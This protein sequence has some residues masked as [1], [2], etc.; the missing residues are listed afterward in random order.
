MCSTILTF[1]MTSAS[2]S[3]ALFK[4]ILPCHY[5]DFFLY[6]TLYNFNNIAKYEFPADGKK[7]YY[8]Y[9]SISL[10]HII[11][12]TFFLW[13]N[14]FCFF[15]LVHQNVRTYLYLASFERSSYTSDIEKLKLRVSSGTD[16]E[17]NQKRKY[18]LTVKKIM[19]KKAFSF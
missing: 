3:S 1:A 4:P 16:N 9:F 12:F 6:Y 19:V 2:T 15:F 17:V 7:N 13:L 14:L 18:G 8:F 11:C 10:L 5:V